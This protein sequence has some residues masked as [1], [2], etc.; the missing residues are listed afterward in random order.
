MFE[1]ELVSRLSDV[2]R[3]MLRHG[4]ASVL[5]DYGLGHHIPF[6]S[7]VFVKSKPGVLSPEKVRMAF[8]DLGGAFV[9]L[10]QVL[11]MSPDLVPQEFCDEFKKL[12]DSSSPADFQE[13]KPFVE[14]ELKMPLE[15]AFKEFSEKPVGSA[16][17]AQVHHAI[18]KN[19]KHVVVKVQRPRIDEKFRTD[20]RLM[21]YLAHKIQ[22]RL[23]QDTV[24]PLAIIE[25]FEKYTEKELNFIYEARNIDRFCSMFA[26]SKTVV[27]P[28]VYWPFCSKKI[29]VMDAIHGTKISELKNSKA[30]KDIIVKHFVD[31]GIVQ[32]FESG[33]AHA[34]LHA[35]NVLVLPG[36]KIALL[37]FGITVSID[38]QL[39]KFAVETYRALAEKDAEEVLRLLCRIG[40]VT[41]KT[42]MADFSQDVSSAVNGWYDSKSKS[43][44]FT[45]LFYSLFLICIKHH[46]KLPKELFLLGKGLMSVESTCKEL[47]PDFDFVRYT[48]KKMALLMKQHH[49]PS[50][51]LKSAYLR[52]ER[53][54][55]SILALPEEAV[56]FSEKL[57]REGLQLNMDH[58]DVRHLGLD[59]NKSSNRVSFALMTASF[60]IA[61][62]LLTNIPPFVYGYSLFSLASIFA[63][64]LLMLLLSFSVLRE[65]S[66]N[67]D[68]H[69]KN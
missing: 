9:K 63:A 45:Q 66:P 7:R 15:S 56:S 25:E 50:K 3:V 47:E 18:L 17:V 68:L 55:D 1:R 28:K 60:V 52:S 58:T 8:E 62:A 48:E 57:R 34:D 54:A 61:S 37:D 67:Y 69:N 42:K 41:E 6:V 39:Q 31:A 38:K 21:Y 32:F 53:F 23:K 43:V 20:I 5:K 36:N 22:S 46:V 2:V 59:I 19:G 65:G 26:G 35:G 27:I 29:I 11:S 64:A 51:I 30:S 44:G 40:T 33:F 12:L 13:I 4:F 24:S 14:E 10:G 49:S 16:S